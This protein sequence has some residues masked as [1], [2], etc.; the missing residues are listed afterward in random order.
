MGNSLACL[1]PNDMTNSTRIIT[2][3]SINTSPF[4]KRSGSTKKKKEKKNDAV[5]DNDVDLLLKQQALAAALL[6]Q[7]HQMNT[8]PLPFINRSTSVVYP[9]PQPKKQSFTRSSS[10][11]RHR[12]RSDTLNINH[13]PQLLLP[14]LQVH[15]K[16]F[17][18][19]FRLF[20]ITV[21]LSRF[22][23]FF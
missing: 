16:V 20:S 23:F 7:Q 22:F 8:S 17:A 19:C 13:P 15:F 6:F 1:V 11:S 9:S 12:S 5:L 2:S 14:T 3:S 18:F 4:S 10:T 21:G